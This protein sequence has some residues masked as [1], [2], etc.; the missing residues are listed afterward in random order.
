MSEFPWEDYL[1]RLHEYVRKD[2]LTEPYVTR[3]AL[4]KPSPPLPDGYSLDI[5]DV[6]NEDDF[7]AQISFAAQA[8]LEKVGEKSQG[9]GT[10]LHTH[11]STLD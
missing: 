9:G 7:S 3:H 6:Q 2:P 11:I 10:Y 5:D 4:P 1:M 8:A